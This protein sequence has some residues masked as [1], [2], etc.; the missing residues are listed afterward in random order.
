[1]RSRNKHVGS[2][3]A[4]SEAFLIPVLEDSEAFPFDAK[5]FHADN[6]SEYINHQVAALL[7][8]LHRPAPSHDNARASA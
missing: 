5:G 1:M 7:E 4:I 3:A 6:G 2:V 8:K